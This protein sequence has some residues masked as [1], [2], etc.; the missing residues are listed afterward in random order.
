MA[1]SNDNIWWQPHIEL[2]VP[3]LSFHYIRCCLLCHGCVLIYSTSQAPQCMNP[4]TLWSIFST[5]MGMARCHG[6]YHWGSSLPCLAALLSFPGVPCFND[7]IL[8]YVVM[9]VVTACLVLHVSWSLVTCSIWVR[10]MA[11]NHQ[12]IWARTHSLCCVSS[13]IHKTGHAHMQLCC[14]HD[15][16]VMHCS[17]TYAFLVMGLFCRRTVIMTVGDMTG[18]SYFVQCARM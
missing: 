2:M 10:L 18:E 8:P 3:I 14:L 12:C 1:V 9:W 5:T 7:P 16:K 15:Y 6:D 17:H 11:V 4:M 13:D